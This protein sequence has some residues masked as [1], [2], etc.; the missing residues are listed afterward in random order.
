MINDLKNK[1]KYIFITMAKVKVAK[2]GKTKSGKSA[3]VKST[4]SV[5]TPDK[6]DM[7]P[8]DVVVKQEQIDVTPEEV[9]TKTETPKLSANI[10]EIAVIPPLSLEDNISTNLE[11]LLNTV[12]N[13]IMQL[14]SVQTEIKTSQKN[15]A[16]LLKDHNKAVSKKKRSGRKPS[17]FAKPS[18]ISS[19]MA[20]FLGISSDIE[21]AR[22]EVTSLINKYIVQHDLRNESDKRKI[23]PDEKLTNLLNLK[24][25]E[26]LS[27]FNLQK[28][29][30]HHFIK[31]VTPVTTP[32][33]TA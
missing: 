31:T 18:S 28:Y 23:L 14:K 25:D 22:N 29:M 17:G 9:E 12:T 5:V 15:Y 20:E 2:S 13:V 3:K 11:T 26:E 19:E 6:V 1:Y 33:I 4:K 24:G 32:V 8:V 16:K 7:V 21:I 10:E 27:Y 30:K